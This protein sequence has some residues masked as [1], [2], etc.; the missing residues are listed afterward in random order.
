MAGPS[1]SSM[2]SCT[3]G[4]VSNRRAWPSMSWGRKRQG[5]WFCLCTLESRKHNWVWRS[6]KGSLSQILEVILSSAL[7][8]HFDAAH[9][10]CLGYTSCFFRSCLMCLRRLSP[11]PW[12]GK[13]LPA[14]EMQDHLL[15]KLCKVYGDLISPV[16]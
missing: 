6:T 8:S 9:L 14:A 12:F 15:R 1:F 5:K 2:H 10:L 7:F 16:L 13:S 4:S 3:V 11:G